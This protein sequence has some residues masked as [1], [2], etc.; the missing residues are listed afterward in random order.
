M[1][2]IQLLSLFFVT[3]VKARGIT[4]LMQMEISFWTAFSKSHLYHWRPVFLL[5]DYEV[6]NLNPDIKPFASYQS[7]S[8]NHPALTDLMTRV[9]S[10]YTIIN[11]P[12]LGSFPSVDF[13][14]MIDNS[15][16][17]VA[18]TGVNNVVTMACGTCS[19]ENAFKAAFFKYMKKQRGGVEWPEPEAI[20]MTTCLHNEAP[21]SPNLSILSF[22][23]SLHGRALGAL[24]ATRSRPVVKLDNPALN[25]PA[26]PF[27]KLKYPL[28]D[29]KQEN[30]AEE[31]RCLEIVEDLIEQWKSK[32]P[33]AG[34]IIE[35]IQAE[36]GDNHASDDFFRKLKTITE[37]HDITFICDEVQTSG[38]IAGRWWAHEYWGLENPPDIVS[39]AKKMSTGGFF[40]TDDMKWAQGHR[41][42]N[43]WMGDPYKLLV[44]E[45]TIDV[46]SEQNLINKADVTGI[47]LRSG[48]LKLENLFPNLM[49]ATRGRGMFCAVDFK[50]AAL[51][52]QVLAKMLSKGVLLG[53]CGLK[54]IRFRPS[55]LFTEY[56]TDIMLDK[57]E[58]VLK[59]IN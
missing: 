6:Y 48:L 27:P 30:E 20:E 55:L 25:W 39:F 52:D 14:E 32:S 28:D 47:Y 59:D 5:H 58:Q 38:G 10:Q 53:G 26:A 11:R 24:S 12:A 7:T 40:Y 43:T 23:G 1:F 21:G 29:H 54:T 49:S 18:P 8:Y 42:Y 9:H 50:D 22:Y 33:V 46:V 51:R 44:L 13:Q 57:L 4:L 36:G 3:S 2:R 16:S 31:N 37:K 34:L 41:I 56:H 17:R 45:K 15:L 35:P 19:N